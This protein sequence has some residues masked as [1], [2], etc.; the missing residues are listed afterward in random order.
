MSVAARAWAFAKAFVDLE[1][2][3]WKRAIF[4]KPLMAIFILAMLGFFFSM[5]PLHARASEFLWWTAVVIVLY[6]YLFFMPAIFYLIDP[7]VFF[8]GDRKL[9]NER[10]ERTKLERFWSD[11]LREEKG[12][13]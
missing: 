6:G 7:D 11:Y 3:F 1:K 5:M 13:I 9:R 12:K 4:K 10:K 2:A 8:P